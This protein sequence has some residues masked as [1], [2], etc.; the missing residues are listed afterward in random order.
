MIRFFRRKKKSKSTNVDLGEGTSK[1][2][3]SS[4]I[5]ELAAQVGSN[6]SRSSDI[7]F[8]KNGNSSHTT[9]SVP[10]RNSS[11]GKASKISLDSRPPDEGTLSAT[12][13]TCQTSA[14]PGAKASGAGSDVSINAM[15][16]SVIDNG[17]ESHVKKD[18]TNQNAD[19][20]SD[21]AALFQPDRAEYKG[22]SSTFRG[23]DAIE[24]FYEET[25]ISDPDGRFARISDAYDTIS[26]IEQT[27]LPRGGVSME[28][29]AIG[30][31]QVRHLYNFVSYSLCLQ[32]LL[33]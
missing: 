11:K 9:P 5:S 10:E 23:V 6:M 7:V 17:T 27:K 19:S 4:N 30:R 24:Q 31:I 14:A 1:G 22:V 20:D 26:V 25:G 21:D 16:E 3:Q 33:M 12:P 8:S 18:V 28:T 29:K 2:E 15:E 32:K 13:E